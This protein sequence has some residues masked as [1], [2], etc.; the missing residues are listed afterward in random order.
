MGRFNMP[1]DVP[2]T[3]PLVSKVIEQ[4]QVKVEGFHFDS[5]KNLVE[6]DDVIN[7]QRQ[8]VYKLRDQVLI[9]QQKNPQLNLE[10]VLKYISKQIESL[11]LT[12]KS[13]ETNEI[14]SQKIVL[15][16]SEI[17]PMNSTDRGHLQ[18]ELQKSEDPVEYL[19]KL[20][21]SQWQT[22][23]DMFGPD[24]A[25]S[26]LSYSVVSTIDPL[27]VE[28]LTALDDLRD[29]VRLRGYAQKDP[30]VEYRKEGYEMF[31]R[32]MA[33]FEYNLARK[34]FRL[35]PVSPQTITPQNVVEGRG[36]SLTE[37][38]QKENETLLASNNSISPEAPIKNESTIG[39][40][41]PC[42]CGSGKK[43]KKCCYP[44]FG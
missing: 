17:L 28:H 16:F 38:P 9:N 19:T 43:Y 30:L 7:K 24:L 27:W 23:V 18:K 4:I 1:E 10:V 22:R 8:I 13:F 2:L 5:R 37:N 3:H 29:G 31:Q 44:K 42:P 21:N 26:I 33:Q 14:D 32:L 40:N 36:N 6:Y 11:V 41:D 12:N 35:E 25:N 39:R 20:L 15:E 34:I